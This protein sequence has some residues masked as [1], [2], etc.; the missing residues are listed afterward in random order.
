MRKNSTKGTLTT[1]RHSGGKLLFHIGVIFTVSVWGASFVSTAVLLRNGLGPV[2]IYI[3]RFTLAYL[4]LLLIDHRKM[5]ANSLH[6]ELIL[7]LCGLTSGSIYYIAENS[8]L[9][10]ASASDVSLITSLSPLI[11][12]MLIGL[13]YRSERPSGGMWI[14][15]IVAFIGVGCII[16]K[17]DVSEGGMSS[18]T[19]DLLALASA[20]SWA[21]YSIL[22]RRISANYSTTFITRKTLFYGVVTALPFLA[23]ESEFAPYETLLETEVWSNL[24]FLGIV[25][26]LICFF[27]WSVGVKRIGPVTSSNYLYFSPVVTMIVAWIVLGDKITVMGY[28][29]CA[30]VIGGLVLGDYLSEMIE[31][32]K[33]RRND[34]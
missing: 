34:G 7:L 4:L 16:F 19:G 11:T 33:R 32:F 12:A 23:V 15:S 25:A 8:S 9:E 10:Y 21:I 27:L 20:V 3:Y 2:E 17:D 29:G 5:M 24:L 6:D 13:L 30:L 22:L 26:S 31:H 28:I 1:Q 18:V 14:G